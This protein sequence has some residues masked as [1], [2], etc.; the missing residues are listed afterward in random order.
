MCYQLIELYSSCHCPYYTHPI[1]RCA[2]SGRPG[3]TVQQRTILVGYN[4]SSHSPSYTAGESIGIEDHV[5][6]H[7]ENA[8]ITSDFSAPSTNLTFPDD[9]KQEAVDR[10]FHELL[11]EFSLRHLWPQ[12]VRLS[13]GKNEAVRIIARY[14]FHL[15]CDLRTQANSRLDKDATKFVSASRQTVADRVVECHINELV[16]VDD[17][18]SLGPKD[19][20]DKAFFRVSNTKNEAYLKTANPEVEEIEDLDTDEKKIIFEHVQQFIFEGA[21]FQNFVSN[22]KLFVSSD[23]DTTAKITTRM[24]Q[25]FNHIAMRCWKSSKL[26]HHTR[27]SWSCASITVP[28]RASIAPN[29]LP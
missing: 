7:D 29:D 8:S 27:I 20:F 3:H 1:D 24:R 28:N 19:A 16:D 10:L 26:D 11:N 12:I 6:D 2:A 18:A 23:S 25:S 13:H 9:A 5:S 22:L 15:S 21:P 4:C 14:L 17:W